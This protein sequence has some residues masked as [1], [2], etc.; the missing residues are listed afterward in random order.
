MDCLQH[1]AN[2][3]HYFIPEISELWKQTWNVV[4]KGLIPI[5]Y[6][7]LNKVLIYRSNFTETPHITLKIS[8][9]STR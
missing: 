9:Y 7:K 6:I 8:R 1:V 5:Q 2:D 4:G 3:Y